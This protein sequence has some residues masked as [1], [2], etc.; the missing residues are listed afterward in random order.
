Q[1]LALLYFE[2]MRNVDTKL[3]SR[4]AA[5]YTALLHELYKEELTG[6]RLEDNN[7]Y[8]LVASV[9]K[10][11]LH[12]TKRESAQQLWEV[13][14]AEYDVQTRA[15][16]EKTTLRIQPMVL[17]LGLLSTATI[18]RKGSRV[19]EYRPLFQRCQTAFTLARSLV[20]DEDAAQLVDNEQ[21]MDIMARERVKWLVGLLQQSSVTDMV[22]TGKVLLDLV[23]ANEP[24]PTVLSMALTLA[25]LE[26]AQWN[27]ILLPYLVRL[28]T[29]RWTTDRDTLLLFWADLFQNDLFKHSGSISSVVTARGQVLFP[30]KASNSGNVPANVPRALIEWLTEPIDWEAVVEQRQKIP[31][32]ERE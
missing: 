29:D 24:L 8:E 16:A 20:N 14:L 7:V 2:C 27:Q 25:R 19:S 21:A 18:V 15:V 30:A 17:L 28:T 4:A 11:C 5:I 13:L 26:W 31:T 1:G 9:T 23:V 22:S 12:Y 32:G 10:L 6:E 3:H